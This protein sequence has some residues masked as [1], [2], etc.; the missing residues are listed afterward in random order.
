[1][2]HISKILCHHKTYTLYTY[3]EC[4]FLLKSA[5]RTWSHGW[6]TYMMIDVAK[7][8]WHQSQVGCFTP[9]KKVETHIK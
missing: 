5:E 4:V 8:F 1:M 3:V 9:Y 2:N 6:T 7:A